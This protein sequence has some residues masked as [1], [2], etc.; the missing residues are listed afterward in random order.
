MVVL[1]VVALLPQSRTQRLLRAHK[2]FN[3]GEF[4]V[5]RFLFLFRTKKKKTNPVFFCESNLHFVFEAD[6]IKIVFPVG[7]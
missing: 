7:N 2:I 1:V 5:L 6:C 3:S 4:E